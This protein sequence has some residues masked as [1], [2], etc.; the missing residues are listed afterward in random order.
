M[1]FQKHILTKL[2]FRRKLFA[3]LAEEATMC[4]ENLLNQEKYRVRHLTFFFFQLVLIS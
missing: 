1:E 3:K 2:L 4:V